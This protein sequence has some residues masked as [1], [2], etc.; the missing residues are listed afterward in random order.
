MS[1][2]RNKVSIY[3]Y[4]I[5]GETIDELVSRYPK[6]VARSVYD[7][8]TCQI[9]VPNVNKHSPGNMNVVNGVHDT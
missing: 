8:L 3:S 6:P 7:L 9:S 1:Q 5:C 4:V 2:C